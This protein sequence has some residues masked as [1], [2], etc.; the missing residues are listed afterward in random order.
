MLPRTSIEQWVILRAIVRLGGFAQAADALHKSQSTI[1]YAMNRLQDA[2]GAQ[3]L[4]MHGRRAVLTPDGDALLKEAAPLIDAFLRLEQLAQG[5]A[6][7][8]SLQIRILVDAMYPSARLFRAIGQLSEL[9]PLAAVHVQ[10]SVRIPFEAARVQEF[11]LAIVIAE[12]GVLAEPAAEVQLL[13]IVGVH[14]PLAAMPAPLS[15]VTLNSYRCADIRGP[16]FDDAQ[17]GLEGRLWKLSTVQMA[18]EA[19]RNGLCYAWLPLHMVEQDLRLKQL[20]ALTLAEGSTRRLHLGL[21]CKNAPSAH[22]AVV[23]L[24]KLL[25]E[26]NAM[27]F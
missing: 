1:S 23:L 20:V 18:L 6:R 11:D 7:G 2:V 21:I 27:T 8:D 25:R 4:H 14:H 12:P 15:S 19:V 22:P 16:E 26:A 13:P 9:Y 5:M 17:P 3:L 10:E 24:A